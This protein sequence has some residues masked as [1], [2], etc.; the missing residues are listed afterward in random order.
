MR[1]VLQ[2]PGTQLRSIL[3]MQWISHR[4]LG[5]S[6]ALQTAL[7]AFYNNCKGTPCTAACALLGQACKC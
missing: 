2:A 7:N 5:I 3:L 1:P 4:S 6:I